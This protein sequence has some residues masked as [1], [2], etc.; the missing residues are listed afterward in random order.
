VQLIIRNIAVPTRALE[1][2][3]QIGATALRAAPTLSIPT[4]IL[5]GRYDSVVTPQT[6]RVLK[7]RMVIP[8]QYY[9]FDVGHSLVEPEEASWPQVSACVR[10]FVKSIQA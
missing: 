2:V 9:E 3:R 6:T 8:P 5:Q 7:N 4:L 1:Q 10:E